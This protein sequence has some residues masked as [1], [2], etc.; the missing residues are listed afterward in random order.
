MR[1][2]TLNILF[3]IGFDLFVAGGKQTN[4]FYRQIRPTNDVPQNG[5]QFSFEIDVALAI[6]TRDSGVDE[7]VCVCVLHVTPK[8]YRHETAVNSHTQLIVTK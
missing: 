2:Q 8:Q 6:G 3:S 4:D 5:L 7:C 1:L